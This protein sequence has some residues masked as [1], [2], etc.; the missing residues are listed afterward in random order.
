MEMIDPRRFARGASLESTALKDVVVRRL[1]R[2]LPAKGFKQRKVHTLPFNPSDNEQEMFAL[3]DKI[4]IESAKLNGTKSGGDIVTMLLKKRF[5]SSPYAFGRTLTHYIDSRGGR[6]LTDDDYDDILGEGQSDEEEGLSDQDEAEYLRES[7]TSDPLIAAKPGQLEKLRDWGLSFES[8]PDS[9]ADALLDFLE[10]ICRP[11]GVHW[12]NERVVVFT[13]YAHTVEWLER[14]LNQ[15]GYEGRVGVIQGSTPTDDRE[16]IKAQ[17]NEDPSKEPIRI[18]LATDAAGEGIDLQNHCSRL[19]CIDT[20]WN[21][22]RLEQR[23]GRIDRYGQREEPKLYLFGPDATASTFNA[24][25]DFMMRI[26]RKVANIEH[27]LGSVGQIIG[28]EIQVHF[29][30]R[31]PAKA[32][33]KGVDANE[34]INKALA[35]GMELNARLTQLEQGYDESRA[36]MHLE[37]S[38]LRRVVDTAL[39]INHQPALIRSYEFAEDTES[40]VFDLPVLSPGWRSTTVGLDTRLNPGEIRPITFDSE[41]AAEGRSDVVYVHLGHP[42]VQKAQRLLRRSLWS[43]DSPLERVTAVVVE[44]LAESFVAA[45]TRMVLVGRGGVRLHEEVFLAGVRI[46]GRRAMAEEKAEAALDQALDSQDLGLANERV[47]DRLCDM[48]NTPNAPLRARLEESMQTRAAKRH[49]L[50]LEQLRKRQEADTQRAQGI[51][52]AFRTNLRDSLKVLQTA[53]E[54]AAM[55]LLP[56]DQQNQRRRDIANMTRRLESLDAEEARE[57][58]EITERYTDV[59]P[60]TMAAAIAFAVTAED[61]LGWDA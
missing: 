52:A 21:P 55:M 48:W 42:I 30:K 51:F 53:E 4:V 38:N 7:K 11:D 22:A 35:G 44:D 23:I 47:R 34:E 18:L 28:D 31:K 17:F 9:K 60:H 14:I 6:G 29:T 13:E 56:D 2:D 58:E 32:K 3:L 5:L 8:R 46:H 1:K 59:K 20:P 19:V 24:D 25:A 36:A 15:K 27:D 45:V 57:I 61:A 40:E 12:L 50:I 26:A 37:P 16:L 41:L 49:D 43:S 33:A 54:E 39:R 10:S